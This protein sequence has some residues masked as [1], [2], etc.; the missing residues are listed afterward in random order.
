MEETAHAAAIRRDAARRDRVCFFRGALQSARAGAVPL[1]RLRQRAFRFESEIRLRDGLAE[2]L[3][4]NRRRKRAREKRFQRGRAANGSEMRAVRRALGT[5]LH[6][7]ARAD[8]ASLLYEFR[9]A[10]L[11]LPK[12][13][14]CTKWLRN[15]CRSAHRCTHVSSMLPCV[16]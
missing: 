9:G 11:C 2:L 8:R 3:G 10:A 1:R 4:T 12:K 5:C 13:L 15:E 6:G 16:P 7:R 14:A